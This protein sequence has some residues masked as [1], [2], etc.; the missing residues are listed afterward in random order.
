MTPA[1]LLRIGALSL[2]IFAGVLAGCGGGGASM[3]RAGGSSQGAL[4]DAT[5]R[6]VIPETTTNGARRPAYISPSTTQLAWTLDGTSQTVVTLTPASSG[7]TGSGSSLTCTVNFY[8]APGSHTFNFTLMDASNKPLSAATS[9]NATLVAG[10]ANTLSVTLGG[11]AQSFSLTSSNSNFATPGSGTSSYTM[12]GRAALTVAVNALDADGNIIVGSGSLG[13]TAS[14]TSV[15]SNSPVPATLTAASSN[16]WTLTSSYAPT[17]PSQ[18][19]AGALVVS[20]SPYP[21]SGGSTV[22]GTFNLQFLVPWLYVAQSGAGKIT[23]YNEQGTAQSVSITGLNAPSGVVFG[24]NSSTASPL[25]SPYLYVATVTTATPVPTPT[26]ANTV[27]PS[28]GAVVAYNGDGSTPTLTGSFSGVGVPAGL[29]FDTNLND[30]YVL[31]SVGTSLQAF[32]A[33]GNTLSLTSPTIS[34][35]TGI[36]FDSTND[37]V[38]VSTTT[39]VFAYL[40]NGNADP[41]VSTF[42]GLNSPSGVGYDTNLNEI[43]VLNKGNGT[44]ALY[45]PTGGAAIATFNTISSPVAIAY[46]PYVHWFY[47][48]NPTSIAAYNES[49]TLQSTSFPAL[50]SPTA[51]TVVQ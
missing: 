9:V 25:P 27:G 43:A 5:L 34:S 47:V 17:Y 30:V 39:G 4:A 10:Q 13:V 42:T 26:G 20:A 29:A 28:T 31:N 11:I 22:N 48:A 8:V 19:G 35:P 45:A 2:T 40:E 21:N 32:D 24:A 51:I 44:I 23:T 14:I 12:Y 38:Y 37:D 15:P 49:G 36:V 3:P 6:I 18:A 16:T 1:T 33:Q 7:C 46:D 50:S 41:A